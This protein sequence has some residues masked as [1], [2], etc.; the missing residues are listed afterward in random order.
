MHFDSTKFRTDLID[1]LKTI[2]PDLIIVK[3]F[4]NVSQVVDISAG[5]TM[6]DIHIEKVVKRGTDY[7]ASYR[8]GDDEDQTLWMGDR[9]VRVEL[10]LF[11]PD[12]LSKMLVIRDMLETFQYRQMM[13][14]KGMMEKREYEEPIDTTRIHGETQYVESATYLTSF[15]YS[16]YYI[17]GVGNST[18]AG[19]IEP[20]GTI[21]H[22]TITGLQNITF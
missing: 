11:A 1:I 7:V 18:T 20:I 22:G 3:R 16:V 14:E 2:Y 4:Q 9:E 5:D 12:A 19:S 21:E 8:Y 10:E 15:H 17:D 13:R 6:M